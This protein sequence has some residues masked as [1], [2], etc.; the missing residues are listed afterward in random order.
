MKAAVKPKDAS[1]VILLRKKSNQAETG[2]EVLMVLRHPDSSF[3]PDS[4]VFPGGGL[5]K[6]DCT[7]EMD[8]LCSGIDQLQA[9]ELL[10]GIPSPGK[11]LGAWV[12]AIR[13]T[14][15]EVGVLLAYREDGKLL[16]FQSADER[17]RFRRH[18]CLLIED[19]ITFHDILKKERLTLAADRL[20]Y[21]SHWIT[22]WF[23]PIRYDVRFFV[24]ETPLYQETLHDGVELT[25]HI[26]ISPHEL[27]DGAKSGQFDMVEPTMVTIKE[28]AGFSTIREVISSTIGKKIASR[29]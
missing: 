9:Y 22:P 6:S 19:R 7:S 24:S 3:V 18:R 21:F 17:D 14:F 8:A 25:G 13:E 29:T 28:I 27:L 5:Q 20:H 12:A 23:L 16:E 26:W 11:A 2:F 10:D 1:T 4:Y 15:E